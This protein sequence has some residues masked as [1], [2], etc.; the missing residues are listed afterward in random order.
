[1]GDEAKRRVRLYLDHD[2]SYRLAEQL[3]TR[4]HD[5]VGAWEVGNAGL[6]DPA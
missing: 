1:M 4:G 6:D 3:R 2:I 5:A